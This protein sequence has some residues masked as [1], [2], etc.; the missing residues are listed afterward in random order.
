MTDIP[1][2]QRTLALALCNGIA[3]TGLCHTHTHTRTHLF[4]VLEESIGAA[5]G[6]FAQ[7]IHAARERE[8]EREREGKGLGPID[9]AGRKVK[10]AHEHG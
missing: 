3:S 9:E 1:I 10:K 6:F 5:E 8:R 4:E 7:C 2:T